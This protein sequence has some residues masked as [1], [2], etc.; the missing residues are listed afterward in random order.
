M[1]LCKVRKGGLADVI[2]DALQGEHASRVPRALPC[3][4]ACPNA[5]IVSAETPG[6]PLPLS[7]LFCVSP[8]EQVSL[9]V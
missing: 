7:L 9:G 4:H 3:Q 1:T 5:S 8:L 6:F 2:C